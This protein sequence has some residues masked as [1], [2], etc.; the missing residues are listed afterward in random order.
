MGYFRKTKS[1]EHGKE[2]MCG[3]RW[4]ERPHRAGDRCVFEGLEFE[5]GLEGAGCFTEHWRCGNSGTE[6]GRKCEHVSEKALRSIGSG[7]PRT[8]FIRK[9]TK[10]G[11]FRILMLWWGLWCAD[12][13]EGLAGRWEGCSGE[14][15]G[16]LGRWIDQKEQTRDVL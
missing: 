16:Q 5:M 15:E 10:W 9:A 3:G 2:K 4:Q 11:G 14:G 8:H 12:V 13:T 6:M 1:R 7:S